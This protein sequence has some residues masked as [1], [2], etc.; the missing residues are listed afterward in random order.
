[1]VKEPETFRKE[2]GGFVWGHPGSE[3]TIKGWE[4][5]VSWALRRLKTDSVSPK[6]ARGGQT[7][8]DHLKTASSNAFSCLGIF[9]S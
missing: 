9:I 5:G 8:A 6:L 3:D 7:R 4:P 1:M 2:P